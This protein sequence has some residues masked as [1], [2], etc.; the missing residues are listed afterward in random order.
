ME[1]QKTMVKRDV[2][3]A[4]IGSYSPGEPVPFDKIEE[5]LGKI[6]DAPPKI[7]DRIE[8]MRPIMKEMLG[9]TQCHY[10]LD[11]KTRQPTDDNVTMSCKSARKALDAAGLKATDVDLLMYAGI[12][13]EYICPPTTVLIQEEL[14]I[15]CCAE[16]SIHSNCTSIYKALQ[17]ASDLVSL[18]R[19]KNALV[20]TA[21]LSSSFLRAEYFNQ[22][23]L[24]MP[25]ILLR[26]FLSDAA[27]A[28]VIT[29]DPNLGRNRFRVVDTYI[30]SRG[31][32]LGP[33]MYCRVGGHRSQP[34]EIFENG[35]HHLAQNFEKVARLAPE[36]GKKAFDAMVE[37]AGLDTRTV[38]YVLLNVPT[39]HISDDAI[40]ILIKEQN[41][42]NAV[43]YT[44]LS[45]RGYP[46]PCAIIHGLEGLMN[47]YK[48][49][50]GDIVVSI[51]AESSKWMYGGFILEYVG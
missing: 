50:K 35:W 12:V 46:G 41:L 2:F 21:Q 48:L 37:K 40:Q 32:G 30:D 31:L 49:E 51:V 11:P 29:S 13:M 38:K 25:E 15:P 39:K 44:K 4:G 45:E 22:K 14:K 6:T 17:V 20:C 36:L 43:F 1:K 34:L 33:D 18:G 5:V 27:G 7:M 26:W 28:V 16:I 23:V 9:V 24:K 47:E 19:Y 3:I 10:A 8:R 42:G